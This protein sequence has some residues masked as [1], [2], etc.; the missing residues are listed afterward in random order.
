MS[1]QINPGTPETKD[2][3]QSTASAADQKQENAPG[4]Q[5]N[6]EP[7]HETGEK[8]TTPPPLPKENVEDGTKG[9]DNKDTDSIG[10]GS[11]N[12]TSAASKQEDDT[13]NATGTDKMP[14]WA[15][16]LI[17][18]VNALKEARS[19]EI[20]DKRSA[21]IEALIAPLGDTLK[22]IYRRTETAHLTS[23]QFD[24]LKETIRTEVETLTREATTRGAVFE[25]PTES[26]NGNGTSSN[27]TDSELRAVLRRLNL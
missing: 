24:A 19:A 12:G 20:N 22:A 6:T 18:E 16:E 4:G 2:G 11:S 5:V 7:T 13:S 15:R 26:G 14:D 3:T 23:D 25:R 9:A 21:D 10:K 8:G 27:A 1:E 17:S